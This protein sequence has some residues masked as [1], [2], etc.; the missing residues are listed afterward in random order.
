MVSAGRSGTTLLR[1][2][3]VCG[4]QIAIP[5]ESPVFSAAILQFQSLQHLGWEN[6]V[7][8]II[9]L[10]ESRRDF[11]LWNVNFTSLYSQVIFETPREERSL[12]RILDAVFMHYATT[13]FPE[14]KLWGDQ[15]PYHTLYLHWIAPVFP[16]AKYLHVLRDGRDA[17]ASM[18]SRGWTIEYATK[19]W[20][21]SVQRALE[22]RGKIDSS[23][24]MEVRYEALASETVA[25][26]EATCAF[27]GIDYNPAMLEYWKSTTTLEHK[28]HGAIHQNLGKP[29]FT[30]SIGTWRERLSADQQTYLL[31]RISGLLERLDYTV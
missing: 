20:Q 28:H 3:L 12:A 22:L 9:S 8:L 2:M 17:V 31:S 27:S 23:Q 29:V 7:R 21:L 11:Q 4:G 19:R 26:L 24:F 18:V 1:S 6:L 13:H 16:Q 30:S 14:A 25:V 5:P 15:T 10:F